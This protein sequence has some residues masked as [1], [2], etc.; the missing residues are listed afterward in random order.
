[1]KANLKNDT[2]DIEP[3]ENTQLQEDLS[4]KENINQ[5]N[6]QTENGWE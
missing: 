2:M 4:N 5:L 3:K 1:M 6:L